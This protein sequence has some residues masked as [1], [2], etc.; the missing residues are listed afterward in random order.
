MKYKMN[1]MLALDLF[2]LENE[3]AAVALETTTEEAYYHMPLLS[4]D[5][6]Y[7][8]YHEL[9]AKRRQEAAI[10]AF[11]ELQKTYE[12]TNDWESIFKEQSFDALVVTNTDEKIVWV[13]NGFVDMT[14]YG[15][16]EVLQQSPK[17][18]QGVATTAESKQI[19]RKNIT[20]KTPFSTVV[21]NYKKDNTPY[22]CEL[23]IYPLMVENVT[24][25]LALESAV[26]G[27]F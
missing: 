4:W 27:P 17:M 6:H 12:W 19:I 21:L 26:S 8:N 16:T 25:F 11:K 14:G 20:Q 5:M 13:S 10:C 9:L 7:F 24:H 23:K 3:D 1:H 18:L 15:K 2:M 22:Y